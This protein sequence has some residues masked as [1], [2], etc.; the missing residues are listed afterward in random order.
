MDMQ[1]PDMDGTQAA[2]R[3]RALASPASRVPII[4][5]TAHAMAGAREE[6]LA[7]GMDDYI[8]K[9][10]DA[11]VLLDRVACL[12]AREAAPIGAAAP[13]VAVLPAAEFDATVG[14]VDPSKLAAL[15]AIMEAGAFASLVHTMVESLLERVARAVH[16]AREPQLATAAREAH[17]I[18]S[19]AGNV[20]AG[21]L[22]ALASELEALCKAGNADASRTVADRMESASIVAIAALREQG[23][24]EAA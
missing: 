14:P 2:A 15:Q 22:S 10:F 17:D 19:I 16:L 4:A 7:A 13:P 21:E 3:I 1:M 6:C 18:V 12:A 24:A 11:A 23:Y 5:L 9:P 8:S 20:G